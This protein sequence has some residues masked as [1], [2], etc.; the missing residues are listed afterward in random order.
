[1]ATQFGFTSFT[2]DQ[3]EA[4]LPTISVARTINK[5]QEHHTWK[6]NYSHF[7]GNN[8]F[9][10][11]KN[12]KNHHV[13]TNGWSDIGQHFSIFPDGLILTGRPLNKTPACIYGQNSRSICIENVGDFDNG[14]DT[15][16]SQQKETI[17]RATAAI[18][19]RFS[20]ISAD[21]KGIVY[22]HWFDLNTG[23]R[24]NGSGSTKSCPGTN[25]FGGNKVADFNTHFLPEVRSK[26]SGGSP[27]LS[28][29]VRYVCVDTDSLN[30]R[31]GP[32]SSH[33]V[34]TDQGPAE[35][36]SILRVFDES[37]KWLK[38]SKTRDHWVY[39]RYTYEVKEGIINTDDT[40]CR[41]APDGSAD[42]IA[43]FDQGDKVY[44]HEQLGSWLRVDTEAWIHHSLV[45]A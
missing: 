5:V 9:S 19:K 32:S 45:D 7:N 40:N 23:S 24:T 33:S 2:I 29:V 16:T 44:V 17:V 18:V 41:I 22:H 26:L 1:M 28:G 4:W 12:M 37:A 10:L 11:Q 31:T 42:V 13:G 6:P 25:F 14:R 8:H 3:F 43:V 21:D 30:I 39:G 36:G 35:M 20:L 27:P 38:I 15:M 34:I